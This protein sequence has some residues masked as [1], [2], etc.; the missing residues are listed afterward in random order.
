MT[1]PRE[2]YELNVGRFIEDYGER[3]TITAGP[4]SEA[5]EGYAARRRGTHWPVFTALSLDELAA[6]LD[7]QEAA[8]EPPASPAP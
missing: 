1:A 7:A 3:W 5:S 6:L 2:P 4:R 8:G